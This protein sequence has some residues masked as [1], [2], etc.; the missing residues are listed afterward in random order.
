MG[1][2]LQSEALIESMHGFNQSTP[3]ENGIS[4]LLQNQ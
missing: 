2:A 3:G 4:T 1:C